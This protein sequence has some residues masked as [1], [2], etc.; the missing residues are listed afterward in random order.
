M[1]EFIGFHATRC[2]DLN[3]HDVLQSGA[4]TNSGRI[5]TC[6]KF[7]SSVSVAQALSGYRSRDMGYFGYNPTSGG[8]AIL[9]IRLPAEN[10]FA[11]ATHPAYA[12][13]GPFQ[14]YSVCDVSQLEIT[15]VYLTDGQIRHLN[16]ASKQLHL[17]GGSFER[18]TA[19]GAITLRAK[20][21]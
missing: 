8:T 11:S 16:I 19:D 4:L 9:R 7:V 2:T 17:V 3:V 21:Y 14:E 20:S 6:V 12:N 15:D 13:V 1:S 5:R 10:I 18:I